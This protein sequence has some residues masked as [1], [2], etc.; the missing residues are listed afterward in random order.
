MDESDKLTLWL[1]Y[2][3]KMDQLRNSFI[4]IASILF[5]VHSGV[6]AL[7][8]EKILNG[9][10][11]SLIM[12][13][14]LSI[15]ILVFVIIISFTYCSHIKK[16]KFKSDIVADSSDKIKDHKKDLKDKLKAKNKKSESKPSENVIIYIDWIYGALFLFTIVIAILGYFKKL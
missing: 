1:N 5:A 4:T 13:M 12:L 3:N 14:I 7:I 2:E 11:L 9:S 6:F 10:L 8:I 16:N 15:L